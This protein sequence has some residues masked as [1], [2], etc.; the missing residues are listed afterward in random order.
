VLLELRLRLGYP[1]ELVL[2]I[3]YFLDHLL[4]LYYLSVRFLELLYFLDL[5]DYLLAMVLDYL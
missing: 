5:L 1:L 2:E 4:Y 3:L